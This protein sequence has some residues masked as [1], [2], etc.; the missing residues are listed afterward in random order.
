[1][2]TAAVPKQKITGFGG[3]I[4]EVTA[5]TIAVLP[6]DKQTEIYDAYFSANGS[7]YTLTRTHIGSCDFSLAEYSYD[8]TKGDTA[9]AEP[10]YQK[11][12]IETGFVPDL[13]SSPAKLQRLIEDEIVKWTPIVRALD[14]KID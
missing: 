3:A 11:M 8:D 10:G 14:V 5:S 9:L 2:A 12:L 13:D 4:T 7:G 6:A 1:M